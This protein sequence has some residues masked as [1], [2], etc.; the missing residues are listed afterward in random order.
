MLETYYKDGSALFS[1]TIAKEKRITTVDA[2][3]QIIGDDNAMT[4][5][6]VSTA[7]ATT[8]TVSE[9]STIAAMIGVAFVLLVLLLTTTSFAEPFLVLAGLGVAVIINAG[10]NLMLGEISFVTNAAG[11]I[12]QLAVSLDYS[13]FLL[14]RFAECRQTTTDPKDAMVEALTMSTTSILS[15]GLTTVIGFLALCLM[16]FRIGPDLGLT[17]AKGVA[18]S[19]ITVFTFM[20][21]LILKTYK[22]IDKTEHRSFM[23]SFQGFGRF[24]SRVMLPMVLVFAILIVPCYLASNANSFYYGASHIFG[25]ATQMELSQALRDIPQVRSIL[26][27]VDTVGAAIPEQYLDSGTLSKLN[28]D[29]YTRMVLTMDAAY[30]GLCTAAAA[31][32]NSQLEANGMDAVTLTPSTY[33]AV[34]MSLLEKLDADIVYQERYDTAL[35]QVTLQ[36]N[37]RADELYRSYVDSQANSVYLA[38]V[39]A[40]ADVYLQTAEGQA[41]VAQAADNM[42]EEQ[43]AQILNAVV[44]TVSA[45]A[46]GAGSLKLNMDTLYSS[47]GKLKL[48]VG[49]LR[50]AVGELYDGTGELTNGTSEFVDQTSDMDTQISDEIDSMTNSFSGDGDTISFVS[51]KNTHVN[52]VQFVIKTAAIEKAEVPLDDAGESAPLTFWQKLLRLV[53]L[54]A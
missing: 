3:R 21:A 53:G 47:T 36:V 13:V 29:S 37:E 12:L 9:I 8:S 18:L 1:V 43:K 44:A 51:E 22:I 11:S 31:A 49:E 40:Q 23:P 16:Q 48:S 17:L 45:A 46:A 52:A 34:L 7:V 35:E 54:Y 24:V 4:G 39:T 28:S 27:Y 26:S 32:L 38:Y 10:S 2:I 14:H 20:P 5:S 42:T 15:S 6:A 33:S 50:D 30:E 25:S 41:L 19:L